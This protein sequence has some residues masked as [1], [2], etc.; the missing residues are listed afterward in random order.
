MTRQKNRLKALEAAGGNL[1]QGCLLLLFPSCSLCTPSECFCATA[2]C[3]FFLF[4]QV[5]GLA[6]HSPSRSQAPLLSLISPCRCLGEG[7][8]WLGHMLLA[9]AC[10]TAL[11][12]AACCAH[13]CLRRA[14]LAPRPRP[15]ELAQPKRTWPWLEAA[16]LGKQLAQC[17]AQLMHTLAESTCCLLELTQ[18]ASQPASPSALRGSSSRAASALAHGMITKRCCLGTPQ[19]QPAPHSLMHAHAQA[20]A[21]AAKSGGS[22]PAAGWALA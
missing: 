1:A 20:Q 13:S 16:L 7:P 8:L 17:E 2:A 10:G 21:R 14:Q 19:A 5:T 15:A 12:A 22:S 6:L 4:K 9:G 3:A 11:L 18:P